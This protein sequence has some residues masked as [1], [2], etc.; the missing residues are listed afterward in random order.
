MP[1][2]KCRITFGKSDSPVIRGEIYLPLAGAK[3]VITFHEGPLR[4]EALVMSQMAPYFL[5]SAILLS[6][7]GAIWYIAIALE[8]VSM[9]VVYKTA[10]LGE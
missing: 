3:A 2:C 1:H 5:Y 8:A 10:C 7:M 4:Q 6:P 9:L